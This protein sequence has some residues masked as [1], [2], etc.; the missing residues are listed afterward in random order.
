[1]TDHDVSSGHIVIESHRQWFGDQRL[2]TFTASLDG[3]RVGKVPP[4]GRVDLLCEPGHHVVR[5][6]QWWYRSKPMQVD[7]PAGHVVTLNADIP[8]SGNLVARMV[9]FIFTPWRALSLSEM[10]NGHE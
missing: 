6:R 1:M 8:R 3:S 2:G 9:T 5:I 10:A 7:V 4:E